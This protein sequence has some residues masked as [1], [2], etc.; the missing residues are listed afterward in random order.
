[1]CKFNGRGFVCIADMSPA[2]ELMRL[3][4]ILGHHGLGSCCASKD[5]N[6]V[7]LFSGDSNVSYA[8][9]LAGFAGSSMDLRF[10]TAFDLLSDSGM[11]LAIIAILKLLPESL[12]I[13]APVCSSFSAM[14][15]HTSE[16][17]AC[18]PL[19]DELKVWVADSNILAG[20]TILLLWLCQALDI[21]FLLEQPGGTCMP[22]LPRFQC[23]QLDVVMMLRVSVWMRAFG[24]SSMKCTLFLSNSYYVLEL[25]I[26]KLCFKAWLLCMFVSTIYF[27]CLACDIQGKGCWRFRIATFVVEYLG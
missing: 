7:E 17:T 8:L 14:S 22:L 10:S 13:F 9:K 2:A 5:K 27:A 12:A 21:A 16:R 25:P 26:A 3:V 4:P 23:F 1:M 11:C 6:F 24:H 15:R 19:G 18:K 20:R